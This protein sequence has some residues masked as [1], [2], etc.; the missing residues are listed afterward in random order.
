VFLSPF[1]KGIKGDFKIMLRKSPLTP[2]FPPGQKPYGLEAKEGY[3]DTFVLL[4][5]ITEG[6]Q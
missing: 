3:K 5:H 1:G 6:L 4:E 2:L